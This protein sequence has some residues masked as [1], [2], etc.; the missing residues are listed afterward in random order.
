[1]PS[2]ID[3]LGHEI[4]VLILDLLTES[5]LNGRIITLDKVAI[6]ELDSQRRLAYFHVS[7]LGSIVTHVHVKLTDGSAAHDCDLSLLWG[8]WNHVGDMM[9]S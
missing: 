7:H 5:I 9:T 4:M 6:D 1:M 8:G 3:D 2:R